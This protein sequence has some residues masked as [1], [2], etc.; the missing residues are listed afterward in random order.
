MASPVIVD[1]PGSDGKRGE[2]KY[3]GELA[4]RDGFAFCDLLPGAQAQR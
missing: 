3:D 2:L 4:L 1:L